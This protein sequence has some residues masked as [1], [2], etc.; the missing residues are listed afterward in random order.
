[1]CRHICL[2]T[3]R[4]ILR[5]ENCICFASFLFEKPIGTYPNYGFRA[6]SEY[7]VKIFVVKHDIDFS[8]MSV[9][10]LFGIL[11]HPS[12]RIHVHNT[13]SWNRSKN[14]INTQY[15]KFLITKGFSQAVGFGNSQTVRLAIS[16]NA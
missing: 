1:M 7:L 12:Q 6:D 9:R 5:R 8:F 4:F 2:I 3:Q 13:R 10:N 16:I 15:L 14:L 11:Y